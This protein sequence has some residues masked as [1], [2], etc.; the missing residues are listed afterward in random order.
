[1]DKC[2]TYAIF[3]AQPMKPRGVI[4]QYMCQCISIAIRV[5]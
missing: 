4:E 2:V 3:L 1:M 5:Q